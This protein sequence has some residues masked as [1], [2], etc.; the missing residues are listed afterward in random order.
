M[1][2]VF[3]S[4]A[5]EDRNFA[6]DLT[7]RLR[8]SQRTPWQDLRDLRG[9]YDWR[10][11]IDDALREAE[12]LV[13]VMSPRATRSQYVTYE[14]AFA[15]GAGVRVI[16]V[17]REKTR[18]HPRLAGFHYIDFTTGRG[19]P[20]VDLWKALPARHVRSD[21]DP[22][23]WARFSLLD[24]RPEMED[25]YYVI[26]ISLRQAPH[27][28]R[29]VIY[30][31]HDETLAQRTWS[32]KAV[33][34]SFESLIWS[35]GDVLVTATIHMSKAKKQLRIATTL[36]EALRRGHGRNP[37]ENVRKALHKIKEYRVKPSGA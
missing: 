30:E 33:T 37:N 12:V 34:T 8:A 7:R 6:A 16:P 9:G 10:E 15:L 21:A 27:H 20:W 18:L 5:R 23:I 4:Y 19:T 28:V 2:H 36:Y 11:A 29:Q 26:Q 24:G 14:W 35:T 31:L 1:K 32:T 17:L 22:E 3:V 13:V 25:G